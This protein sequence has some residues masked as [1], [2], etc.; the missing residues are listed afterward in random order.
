MAEFEEGAVRTYERTFTVADVEAFADVSN[1]RQARHLDPDED[2]R[3]MVHGL[4]TATL[5]TKIGGDLEVLA[6]RMDFQFRRPVYT[7]Q[8][9]RCR[10]EHESVV[11][12][13]DRVELTVDVACTVDG[14]PVLEGTIEGVVW[15]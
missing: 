7:G 15:R 2:G 3:V 12:R 10:W 5:P 1:D 13:E 14:E 11:E 9:V 4:L 6:S 8:Q